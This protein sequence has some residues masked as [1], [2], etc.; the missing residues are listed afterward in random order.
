MRSKIPGEWLF[1]AIFGIE[2]GK[3][4]PLLSLLWTRNHASI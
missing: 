4:K 1:A 2:T 3:Q